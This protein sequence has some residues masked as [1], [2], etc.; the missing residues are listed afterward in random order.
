M[1]VDEG[2]SIMDDGVDGLQRV[3]LL[4]GERLERRYR[5]QRSIF[6]GNGHGKPLSGICSIC[7]CCLGGL[8]SRRGI[9]HKRGGTRPGDIPYRLEKA[10]QLQCNSGCK[11]HFLKVTTKGALPNNSVGIIFWRRIG[12]RD[13]GYS[14][15]ASGERNVLLM[16]QDDP[17]VL[18]TSSPK[19]RA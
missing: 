11:K 8:G 16:P 2:L 15:R 10:R 7:R 3:L 19:T 5:C 14:V 12:L 13:R 18:T 17:S 4:S 6:V 9:G 1:D